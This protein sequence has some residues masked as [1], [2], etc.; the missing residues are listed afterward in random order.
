MAE[1]V[2][3]AIYRRSALEAISCPKRFYELYEREDPIQ[4]SSDESLRGS[5]FHE[6][7]KIYIK[8][9]ASLQLQMDAEELQKAV[10]EAVTKL[11]LPTHLVKEVESLSEKW[12][13]TFELDLDAFLLAEETQVL[14]EEGLQWTPDLVYARGDE[15]E[16]IAWKT[17]WAGISDNEVKDQFQAQAYVWQ[18]AQKWPGFKRYRFTFNYPRLGYSSS[19]V[20]TA[21]EVE[22]LEVIVKSRIGMIEDCRERGEWEANPGSQCAFCRIDCPVKDHQS[23]DVSR[24]KNEVDAKK[25]AG[26]LMVFEK[27]AT[28]RRNAL[29]AFCV[30]R[31]PVVVNG[32]QW[33]HHE[34]DTTTFPANDVIEVLDNHGIQ[35]RKFYVTKTA[36]RTYLATKK[37][38]DVGEDLMSVAIKKKRSVFGS[39]I[40]REE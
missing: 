26:E 9:L 25:I 34:S 30:E 22:E 11:R 4:D 38:K 15:L 32:V 37:H 36:L 27:A 40:W 3:T 28:A 19:A 24:A 2:A 20:W 18:A 7:A 29:K 33:G 14:E 17:F 21:S 6:A 39:K 12:G 35:D 5:A 16:Q 8:R 13:L 31:G 23:L 10:Y 1:P